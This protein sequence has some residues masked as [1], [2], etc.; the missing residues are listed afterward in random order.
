[1]TRRIATSLSAMLLVAC[2]LFLAVPAA[3]ATPTTTFDESF[4]GVALI[5]VPGPP[6][7]PANTLAH[8]VEDDTFNIRLPGFGASAL[9]M[10]TCVSDFTN[11][12]GLLPGVGTFLLTTAHGATISGTLASVEDA[13]TFRDVTLTITDGTRRFS[14]AT[15]TLH[16][17]QTVTGFVI[18]ER[19]FF[20]NHLS[21]TIDR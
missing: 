4:P 7:C 17:H 19:A 16:L 12:Q 1:M 13:T 14:H 5:T 9:H 20:D 2:M 11:D 3:T 6:P 21:G 8:V 18:L 15:G 10:D